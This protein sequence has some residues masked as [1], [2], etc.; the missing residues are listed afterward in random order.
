MTEPLWNAM[1]VAV[2]TGAALI[3]GDDWQANG[4]SIDTRSLK[5][6]D[7]F[8]ALHAQRDGHAYVAKAYEAGAVAALVDRRVG[9]GPQALVD[10]SLVGLARMAS[11]A[12]KRSSAYRVAVTGSVGKSSVKEAISSIFQASGLSHASEKS[13]NNHW[14]V[15]LSLARM[16]AKTLRAVFEIGMNHAG[17]TAPLTALVRPHVGVI[18]R[19]APAHIEALGSLDAIADEK[20][21]IWSAMADNGVAVIGADDPYCAQLTAKATAFGV[22]RIVTF[23]VEQQADVRVCSFETGPEGSNGIM[24]V[25]GEQHS[26]SMQVSGSHWANNAAAAVAAALFC[27]VDRVD[28]VSALS[29]LAPLPGRGGAYTIA[30]AGGQ[31]TLLDDAYN[32][33][34]VSMAAALDTLGKW[35]AKRKIAVLGDMLELGE[36]ARRYHEALAWNIE[37]AG[38]DQ[39]FCTGP[40][41]QYLY[42]SLPAKRQGGWFEHT[43]DL[44]H[45]LRE[46]LVPSDTVLLKGSNGSHIHQIVSTL[47][48]GSS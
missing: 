41:M 40:L 42:K 44:T 29:H 46:H 24:D 5:A 35:P 3:D 48:S 22:S 14:G 39:I 43:D 2:A 27:G 36:H 26:F 31:V 4:I 9:S 21:Q 25:F 47:K 12:R 13:Y 38:I 10:D 34:P 32:A 28:A 19:I 16:P 7:L 30:I 11:Q 45:A 1:E 37:Q 18:T 15:P 8:V 23:G 6:G 17:E 20:A 33:N